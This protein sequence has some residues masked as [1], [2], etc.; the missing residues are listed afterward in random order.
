MTPLRVAGPGDRLR[1]RRL[2]RLGQGRL[3][4]GR[5]GLGDRRMSA[6]DDVVRRVTEPDQEKARRGAAARDRRRQPGRGGAHA[7]ATGRAVLARG[8]AVASRLAN[9]RAVRDLRHRA[10]VPP[11]F[12]L[13]RQRRAVERSRRDVPHSPLRRALG[14]H[15]SRRAA[16]VA[17]RSRLR[18]DLRRHGAGDRRPRAA[19]DAPQTYRSERRPGRARSGVRRA[20]PRSPPARR[21]RP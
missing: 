18:R 4:P 10:G 20:R 16:D 21:D 15:L 9:G 3:R 8:S 1:R 19:R 14:R 5:V 2:D 12:P 11:V 13:D 6:G 7:G 17:G